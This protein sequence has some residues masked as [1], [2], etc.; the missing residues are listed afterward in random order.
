[1]NRGQGFLLAFL[2]AITALLIVIV[3]P[4]ME[5]VLLAVIVGYVL[6][7]LNQRLSRH[8]GDFVAPIVLIAASIVAIVVPISYLVLRFVRDLEAISRGE[9]T[10]QID[11]IE[12]RIAELTGAPVNLEGEIERIGVLLTDVLLGDGPTAVLASLLHLSVGIALVLFLVFYVLRDGAEFVEWVKTVVPLPVAVSNRLVDQ[13]DRTVWGAV[14]GHVFAAFVQ[15]LFA[16]FGLYVAGIPNLIFWTFV[17]FVL[18]FL[19]LIGVFLVWGPAAGYLYLIGD[20]GEAAFLA[21]YGLTIVSMIDYYVR[22]LVIDR[23]A[24]LNPAV[25]LVGV[26][27]GLYT[28]GFVGLFVGPITIGV[29]VATL[30]SIRDDYDSI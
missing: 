11:V 13:I 10:L 7:P 14:I 15:T 17:M 27:G 5:Y 30:Q 8:I 2:A 4:F 24:R 18:A 29:F 19:P 16:A 21:L 26:F 1:M 23:R 22:P 20:T 25:I 6:H 9:T 12:H 3:L 28:F